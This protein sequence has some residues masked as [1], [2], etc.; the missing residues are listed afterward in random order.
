[1]SLLRKFRSL[2]QCAHKPPA[3]QVELMRN[4]GVN[5]RKKHTYEVRPYQE[6]PRK[7]HSNRE[8]YLYWAL[9][10]R[11]DKLIAEIRAN[12]P[13]LTGWLNGG[14]DRERM[15]KIKEEIE[16]GVDGKRL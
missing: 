16:G 3:S 11:C 5:G 14:I 10:R 15:L 13:G 8:G 7:A 4:I 6:L 1:M 2:P 9:A 12:P